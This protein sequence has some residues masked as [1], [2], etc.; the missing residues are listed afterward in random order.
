MSILKKWLASAPSVEPPSAEG[1]KPVWT[2]D[3]LHCVIRNDEASVFV[4]QVIS[5]TG[6]LMYE[7]RHPTE[8]ASMAAAR[9]LRNQISSPQ[10]RE[11]GTNVSVSA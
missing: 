1:P 9:R 4:V 7:D 8:S 2:T 6:Y 3:A 11:G 5:D 10:W